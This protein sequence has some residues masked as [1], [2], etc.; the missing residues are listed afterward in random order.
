M[1]TITQGF[2][3]IPVER[4]MVNPEQPRIYFDEG[5]LEGLA[6]TM[7]EHGVIQPISVEECGDDFILHDGERRWRAAKLADLETIPAY[8]SAPLNGT[9][10]RERLERA[11][12]ANVQRSE[13]HPIEEGF[14]Y[15]RLMDEFDLELKDVVKRTGKHYTRIHY[16]VGL[17]KL[18]KEIQQLM[19][20]RK[21]PCERKACDALMTIGS[22]EERV[23][24]ARALAARN[25]TARMIVMAVQRFKRGKNGG[26]KNKKGSPAEM[27]VKDAMPEWDA[28]YQLG[29]VPPWPAVTEAVMST[30]DACPLRHMA[31]DSICGDCAQ[32]VMLR[33]MLEAV[34]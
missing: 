8:V 6:E 19:M 29:K 23:A 21:L 10:P 27:I 5:E 34:K 20:A 24:L 30:C 31:S 12:V 2:L 18:D 14:A 13:M 22:S 33:K 26:K 9:G 28:L 32:V 7:R 25:A 4:I 3:D 17:L 11:L 16:C 15:Q 1:K